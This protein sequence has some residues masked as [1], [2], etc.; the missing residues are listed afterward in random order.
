MTNLKELIKEVHSFIIEECL[1]LI[2][3]VTYPRIEKIDF[4][5]VKKQFDIKNLEKG[6]AEY[7]EYQL[8]LRHEKAWIAW[9]KLKT[10]LELKD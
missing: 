1:S 4:K 2:G 10:L 9:Q 5:A 8:I 3:S 6:S 7:G